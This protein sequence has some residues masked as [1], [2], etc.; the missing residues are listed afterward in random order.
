M[1]A[2]NP[3]VTCWCLECPKP[4]HVCEIPPISQEVLQSLQ[5]SRTAPSQLSQPCPHR[6]RW[7]TTQRDF[8]AFFLSLGLIPCDPLG[9]GCIA[10]RI[11]ATESLVPIHTV[12]TH[13]GEKTGVFQ[14]EIKLQ[15]S[16]GKQREKLYGK[17]L[18]HLYNVHCRVFPSWKTT[19]K[20][21]KIILA[22][23]SLSARWCEYC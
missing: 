23:L 22:I 4:S 7:L 21:L 16:Q 19:V 17:E 18:D 13:H 9:E 8:S 6:C 3:V 1:E 5:W 12:L 2:Q 10:L 15:T 11:E 20:E 14:G